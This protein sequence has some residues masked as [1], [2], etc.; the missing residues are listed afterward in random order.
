MPKV[1]TSI[2]QSFDGYRYTKATTT[3]QNYLAIWSNLARVEQ[4]K[5]TTNSV[6]LGQ[7]QRGP[8][9]SDGGKFATATIEYGGGT[10]DAP[11]VQFD[12]GRQVSY[13]QT[14][15]SNSFNVNT[16]RPAGSAPVT[17]GWSWQS[18]GSI[19]QQVA[20][21]MG[22]NKSEFVSQKRDDLWLNWKIERDA[23]VYTRGFTS[24]S[25]RDGT[26]DS[27]F[28]LN[29][30]TEKLQPAITRSSTTCTPRYDAQR[31]KSSAARE[32]S[33]T[34]PARRSS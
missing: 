13:S 22:F 4:F 33:K 18:D 24:S 29:A 3:V 26:Y 6:V 32:T 19:P 15:Y 21:E 1:V 2:S 23:K 31:E 14:D 12:G 9:L 20:L 16:S 28:N 8:T 25:N 5:T 17:T 27:P 10:F 34:R 7:F 30:R 11:L